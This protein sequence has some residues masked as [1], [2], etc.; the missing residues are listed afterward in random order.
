MYK[1]YEIKN[2]IIECIKIYLYNQIVKLE[3]T[4][5]K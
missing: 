1:M 4:I 2:V 5:K 3:I